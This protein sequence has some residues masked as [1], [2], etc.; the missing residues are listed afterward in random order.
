MIQFRE[1]FMCE[2]GNKSVRFRC[3]QWFWCRM[4]SCEKKHKLSPPPYGRRICFSF[5]RK[6]ESQEIHYPQCYLWQK[7]YL[8]SDPTVWLRV[9]CHVIVEFYVFFTTSIF[10]WA[11]LFQECLSSILNILVRTLTTW[12]LEATAHDRIETSDII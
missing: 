9:L 10:S 6:R 3:M 11:N 4:F 8:Y 12:K 5:S 7:W 2:N 1:L